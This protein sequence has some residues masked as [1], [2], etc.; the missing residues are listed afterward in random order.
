[1][2]QWA[3]LGV[4][5]AAGGFVFWRLWRVS[6]GKDGCGCG[7]GTCGSSAPR[8]TGGEPKP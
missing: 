1:M 7:C 2:Q 5:F 4:V 6:R 3:V 8:K